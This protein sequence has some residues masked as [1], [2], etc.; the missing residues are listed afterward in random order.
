MLWKVFPAYYASYV[1]LAP[2]FGF[3]NYGGAD[4]TD[5]RWYRTVPG[6][7]GARASKLYALLRQGHYDLKLSP[8]DM[9]RLTV[10]LDSCSLFYG[11]YEAAGG[12]AQL[13]GEIAKPTLE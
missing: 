4:W 11:V 12:Q 3:Y 7:F 1:S 10:W 9:H 5:P 13:R 6:Q 2:Q 8:E